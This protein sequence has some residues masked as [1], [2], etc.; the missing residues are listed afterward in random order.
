MPLHNWIECSNGKLEYTRKGSSGSPAQDVVAWE[1][2]YNDYISIFGLNKLY[3]KMLIAMRKKAIAELDYCITGERFKLTEAEIQERQLNTML[4]N[5]GNGVTIQKTLI[6][7]S[8]WIGYWLNPKNI[9]AREYFDL[10][11]EYEKYNKANTDGKED[12]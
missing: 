6:H 2:I 11:A 8:K 3:K 12:K 10:L 1:R 5:K 4:S 7:L 9:T